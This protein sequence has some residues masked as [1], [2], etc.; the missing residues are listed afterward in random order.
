M[1]WFTR[2]N[3][4]EQQRS[5]FHVFFP[6][7]YDFVPVDFPSNQSNV[8]GGL[9]PWNSMTFHFIYGMSSFPLTNS[10]IF[11]DGEIAPP[12]GNE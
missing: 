12:T 7:K 11:Q 3:R 10:I 2:A 6:S 8:V 4:Q 1:A 9:E 5:I